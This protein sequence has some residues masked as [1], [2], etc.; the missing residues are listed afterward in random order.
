LIKTTDRSGRRFEKDATVKNGVQSYEYKNSGYDR[1]H[2]APAADMSFSE[3]AMNESFLMSNIAPQLPAF[4]RGIWSVLENQVRNWVRYNGALYVVT[5]S[6]WDER[7]KRIAKQSIPVPGYYYKILFDTN[8][9]SKGMIVFLI[10]NSDVRNSIFDYVITV[11]SLE[12][13]TA[14]DFFPQLP[15]SLENTL[16]AVVRKG[17]WPITN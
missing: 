7:S 1:G 16:E 11:D 10:P 14:I 8:K 3:E 15:D 9:S 12:R 2:L 5:G 17:L 4:N 6:I 13:L